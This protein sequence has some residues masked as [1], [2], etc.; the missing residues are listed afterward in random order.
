MIRMW[1]SAKY[2]WLPLKPMSIG[3]T[4]KSWSEKRMP[5]TADKPAEATSSN[6]WVQKK[7]NLDVIRFKSSFR[8]IGN[9]KWIPR[10]ISPKGR[11][12]SATSRWTCSLSSADI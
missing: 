3:Q 7:N 11:C 6:Y 1:V 8:R 2:T 9:W 4:I 10:G 5:V 12:T